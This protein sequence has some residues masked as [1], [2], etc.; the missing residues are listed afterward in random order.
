MNVILCTLN[1]ANKYCNFI[2]KFFLLKKFNEIII[3]ENIFFKISLIFNIK[4]K[5]NFILIW[6]FQQFLTKKRN[7]CSWNENLYVRIMLEIKKIK[8]SISH[9]CSF[10]NLVESLTL[11]YEYMGNYILHNSKVQIGS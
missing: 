6:M 10:N 3:V 4:Y 1:I 7:S 5:V 9:L 11:H 8:L 2:G